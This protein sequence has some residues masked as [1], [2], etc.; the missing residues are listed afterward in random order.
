MTGIA[1]LL[2]VVAIVAAAVFA[3]QARTA[4]AAVKSLQDAAEEARKEAEAARARVREMEADLKARNAQLQETREKLNEARKKAQEGKAGKGQSRGAREAEMEED[5]LHARQLTEQSHAA[6]AAARTQLQAAKADAAKADAEVL[7]LNE[8]VR[9]LSAQLEA[10][11]KMAGAPAAPPADDGRV[12]ELQARAEEA[13]GQLRAEHKR[14]AEAREEAKRARGRAE[15]N[16]RVYLVTKGELEV[17]KERLAQAER[18]LWQAG[19]TL[20]APEQKA[21]P[22]ATGPAAAERDQPPAEPRPAEPSE[23]PEPVRPAAVVAPP[24]DEI[25]ERIRHRPEGAE[26]NGDQR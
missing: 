2:V 10:A 3:L 7:R 16:N 25:L 12:K 1:F 19:L 9:S 11:P 18:R 24:S 6:E 17:I 15:T 23:P 20:P 21:R 26:P 5:L 22:K 13:E 8:R 14:L 4:A